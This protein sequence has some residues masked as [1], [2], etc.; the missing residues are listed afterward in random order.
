MPN[1]NDETIGLLLDTGQSKDAVQKLRE[2]VEFLKRV[3]EGI[4]DAFKEGSY[5]EAEFI[6]ES[7]RVTDKLRTKIDVLERLSDENE[8]GQGFG[9]LSRNVFKAEKAF[10]MLSHPGGGLMRSGPLLE[11]LVLGMGGPAGLGM[12]LGAIAVAAEKVGPH[13]AEMMGFLDPEKLKESADAAK[14]LADEVERMQ[15]PKQDEPGKAFEA[16]LSG[17]GIAGMAAG[18]LAISGLGAQMTP[19]EERTIRNM[20]GMAGP[21]QKI[22]AEEDARKRIA[23]ANMELAEKKVKA[24]SMPGEEGRAARA[25]LKGLA[26]QNPGAFPHEFADFLEAL[27]ETPEQAS[28]AE[29]AIE[30][31]DPDAQYQRRRAAK[32][33]AYN[34]GVDTRNAAMREANRVFHAGVASADE[35]LHGIERA[36]AE[37][38]RT[39]RQVQAATNAADARIKR[40]QERSARQADPLYQARQAREAEERQVRQAVNQNVHGSAGFLDQVTRQAV[41]NVNMGAD[42][43]SAVEFAV[44]M[45]QQKIMRDFQRQFSRGQIVSESNL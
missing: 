5:S 40:E 36:Q 35:T 13:L 20:R 17:Q 11:S 21:A 25:F 34:K 33:D 44:M 3:L 22:Q 28:A 29:A 9:G 19:E 27:E 15:R 30:E 10:E 2:E 45:T 14:K 12:A 26:R 8:T 39:E 23:D 7:D 32:I 6:A 1:P 43:A 31:N 4:K 41:S 42:I 16:A 38:D 24:A 37:K 18:A